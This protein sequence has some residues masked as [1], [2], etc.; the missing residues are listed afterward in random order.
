MKP[1]LRFKNFNNEWEE[2]ELK[3]ITSEIAYG[4]NS[5]SKEYDGE[6]KYIRI[7]DIDENS[8]RY[9]NKD[10]VSPDGILEDKFLVKENDILFA[11]TGAST[12]K[13]YL[14]N[15]NDG[16]L[17]YAGFLI[18]AS[19]INHNSNFIFQQTK[20]NKY[21]NW[22]RI[23]SM[24]SGQPGINS[25]EYGSYKFS[26]TN[27]DEENKISN[28]LSLIDKK[29]ELQSKKIED[30]KLFKLSQINQIKNDDSYKKIPLKDILMECNEKTTVN[31]QYEILSST[32]KGIFLQSEYFNKQAASE[33]NI[34]YKILKRNQ[35]VLSPQNLWMG[36]ININNKYEIGIVSPSYKIFDIK[37]DIVNI[38]YFKNW[39]KSPR[40]LYE[41]M[42][43]SE[44]GA[45][46]VRRNLNMDLFGEIT[47]SVPNMNEQNKI[48][49]ILSLIDSKISLE[50]SKYS[51]LS[52]LK[53]GLMQDMFV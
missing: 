5:A 11:R 43:S 31:N 1:K 34:G 3:N 45:S 4:M 28:F 24:R 12:G 47:I 6:N 10:V 41:Y 7:T 9:S 49:R 17:Y 22:I 52:E 13:T 19:I 15:S 51:K 48:G 44:Q 53:K 8:N 38:D 21:N 29:I 26:I 33:N 32:A 25:Q 2:T 36:N 42:I 30:L 37:T 23:M 14:Y 39:I 35:L 27:I 20:L 50:E 16:K 18:K 40:A 46:I